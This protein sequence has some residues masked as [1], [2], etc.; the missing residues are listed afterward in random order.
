MS[1][2]KRRAVIEALRPG[3]RLGFPFRRGRRQ[4]MRFELERR[5]RKGEEVISRLAPNGMTLE[6]APGLRWIH[7]NEWSAFESGAPKR[8][9]QLLR[10]WEAH[11]E[12]SGIAI[13]GKLGSFAA[14]DAV[15]IDELY[16]LYAL[17]RKLKRPLV[18]VAE[19]LVT[20]GGWGLV[21][22]RAIASS[23]TTM[24]PL[25]ARDVLDELPR[26]VD[27]GV[28]FAL[29]RSRYGRCAALS[30][31]PVTGNSLKLA[32]L[33]THVLSHVGL[34][35]FR[36][37]LA[38]LAENADQDMFV[39]NIDSVLEMRV[40]ASMP[41]VDA[42]KRASQFKELADLCFEPSSLDAIKSHL[43]GAQHPLA[44][45]ANN[46]I[47]Q[48]PAHAALLAAFLD[49]CANLPNYGS[50]LELEKIVAK[51]LVARPLEDVADIDTY[52]VEPSSSLQQDK[53][54]F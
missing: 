23:D 46:V 29:S 40:I 48:F 31:L 16:E 51:N 20:L 34:D 54:G 19:G 38:D 28:G 36:Q 1:G 14:K 42:D 53:L 43:D 2:R 5:L 15:T 18:G 39:H 8:L 50:C 13:D 52:F 45:H 26:F 10:L 17:V 49:K 37:E 6:V 21:G 24:P 25:L 4:K 22:R 12:I 3:D 7:V 35:L 32:G 47:H 41:W 30:G 27:G 33:A 9:S 11:D 44:D